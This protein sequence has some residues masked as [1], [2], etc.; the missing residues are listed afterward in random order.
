LAGVITCAIIAFLFLSS[1]AV[2]TGTLLA[3]TVIG[4]IA[5]GTVELLPLEVDDNFTIP[6]VSGFVMWLGFLAFGL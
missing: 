6:V 3:L 4:G 1:L 2:P 5:G